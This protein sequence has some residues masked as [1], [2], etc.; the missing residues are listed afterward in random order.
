VRLLLDTHV[1]IWWLQKDR[2][3]AH[4][5]RRTLLSAQHSVFVSAASAWE[6]ATKVRN[7]KLKFEPTFLADFDAGVRNLN[8]EPLLVSAHHAVT[9]ARLPGHHGDPFDRVLAGQ[10]VVEKLKLVTSDPAMQS[11]GVETFW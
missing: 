8:F 2:R 9:G 4:R 11:L 1:L 10:A 7:G 3:L 6:I 5:V